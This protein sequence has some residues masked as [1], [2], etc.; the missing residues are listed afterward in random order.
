[1]V[2]GVDFVFVD[3]A[4][5]VEWRTMR[6][7]E[8][9]HVASVLS[10]VQGLGMKAVVVN[11]RSVRLRLPSREPQGRRPTAV[12]RMKLSVGRF[13]HHGRRRVS[14]R[15]WTLGLLKFTKSSY[16]APRLTMLPWDKV[17]RRCPEAASDDIAM[18]A[19]HLVST[20]S[21]QSLIV[22]TLWNTGRFKFY[23]TGSTRR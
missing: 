14:S 8:G 5:V 10:K 18:A 11:M 22:D 9:Y 16:L 23:A 4:S 20:S 17:G 7:S 2:L 13:M 12:N 3:A 21:S 15:V 1:V 19:R 6:G